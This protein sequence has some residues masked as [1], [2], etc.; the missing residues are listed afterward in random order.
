MTSRAFSTTARQLKQL[1]WSLH[2][3]TIDVSWLI[4]QIERS[5]DEVPGL[6]TRVV[7]AQVM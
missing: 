3:T 2:G 6:K 7:S 4:E 5:I 1:N